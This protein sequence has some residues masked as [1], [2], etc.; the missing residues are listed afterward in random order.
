MRRHRVSTS[1]LQLQES[2]TTETLTAKLKIQIGAR[3][4]NMFASHWAN[5]S[6]ARA[7]PVDGQR[8]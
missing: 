2:N 5:N 1:G 3:H 4:H 6:I 8:T 7:D